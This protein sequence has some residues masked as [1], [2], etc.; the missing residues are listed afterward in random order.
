MEDEGGAEEGADEIDFEEEEYVR[1]YGRY[2]FGNIDKHGVRYPRKM[3]AA[4]NKAL[5]RLSKVLEDRGVVVYR[6]DAKGLEGQS[7][8]TGDKGYSARDLIIMIGHTLFISPTP[9]PLC[10]ALSLRLCLE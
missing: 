6:A 7:S 5:D 3:I 1:K 10:F 8:A 9:P 2:A 4:S